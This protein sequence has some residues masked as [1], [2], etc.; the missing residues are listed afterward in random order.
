MSFAAKL[1]AATLF[2]VY[3]QTKDTEVLTAAIETYAKARAS[4]ATFAESANRIYREDITFGPGRFQRGHWSDRLAA[5]DVDL[6]DMREMLAQAQSSSAVK[7]DV[8]SDR[9]AALVKAILSIS[10]PNAPALPVNF[11]APPATFRRGQPRA[12][13]ASLS[14]GRIKSATVILHFRHVN[15]GEAWQTVPM[16]PE[17]QVFRANIPGAYTDTVFPLQ[18]YFEVRDAIHSWLYPGLEVVPKR[19]PY[20]IVGDDV[21]SL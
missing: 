5:I 18:Y 11:H 20:F 1:R 3:E 2:A 6:G 10:V 7:S 21:R 8:S 14:G 16:N 15:Q 12:L 17:H 19:Q 9:P 13:D 4:W